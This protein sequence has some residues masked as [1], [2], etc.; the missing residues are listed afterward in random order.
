MKNKN[1]FYSLLP[2]ILPLLFLIFIGKKDAGGI[3]NK[4][5]VHE[6]ILAGDDRVIIIDYEHSTESNKKITWQLKTS[7]II[8]LPDSVQRYFK[9]IDDAKS[10]DADKRLLISASSGGVVLVDRETKKCLFYAHAPMAHSVE[11]LP[12]DRIAIALS[13]AKEGN[14]VRIYDVHQSNDMLFSDSLYSGHGVSWNDSRK[15]LYALG[16]DRL[17]AYSLR[18]WS[19]DKPSL[20]LE[21]EWELPEIGGHDLFAPSSNNLL[22]STSK[23]V[24]KFN[25][26]TEKFEAFEPLAREE[27]VKSIYVDEKTGQL[28][29]TKGEISWWTHQIHFQNPEKTIQVPEINLYKIRVIEKE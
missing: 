22:L 4:S 12:N 5:K 28:I 6:I 3:S 2:L 16:Y 27:N 8:G 13:T 17:R 26:D 14:S 7:E 21:K 9:T 24:W 10:V 11:S 20:T 19:S 15:R 25:L 29:Y 18:N 1:S 23:G